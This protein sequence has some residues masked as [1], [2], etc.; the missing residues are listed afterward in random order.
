MKKIKNVISFVE[1]L[2]GKLRKLFVN[3]LTVLFLMLITFGFLFSLGESLFESDKVETEDQILYLEP[4]GV[5]VDKAILT[6]DPFEEFEIFESSINQ[7]ELE[8]FLKIIK[9]AGTDDDLKAIYLDVD[10]L[11]AY[12]TSALKIADALYEAR[13][14]GKEIIAFTSGLGTTGYLMASQATEIIL[15]KDTYEPVLPFGFSRVRLY[16]KDFF[17]NIKVNMNVYAAGDFKSG[18]EGYTRNDMSE[19]DRFAWLEFITPIWEK[20]KSKMEIGRGFESGRIQYIGDNYPLLVSENNGDNNETSLTTGLVDKLM[21]EQ[22]TR[23]YLIEKYGSEEEYERPEGISGREYLS[24]LKD[25]D[26]SNKQKR[27][28]EK[29]KIAIIHVEGAIVTG[30]IGF[31]TAGS[32]G[33]VKKINKARDD[34]NV[35]GIVLRVNSPGGDV[36]A[37]TMI[38][39]ALEEFQSTGRPV[40][41]SMGDIAASGGVWVTTTSEEIWAENT[42]LTGSIGVYGVYPDLSPL[43]KWAGINYDGISMTKAGE[44][45]DVRRGMNEEINKQFREGIENFYKDFVTKVANNREMDFSEVLKV[46]GGRIWRGDK[47]LELGLVDKLGSLDDA[48]NSMVTKL[49]LEDYKAFSY[50]NEVEFEDYLNSLIQGMVPTQ[51]QGL[52]NEI[53]GLNRMFLSEKERY[54]VAYCF[55]CGLRSFE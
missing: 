49:E 19:T 7:I 38:T 33:I 16:Q 13:E 46:A 3:T 27:V 21:S 26:I 50:N 14:N 40:I 23:N 6:N 1:N 4:K 36:Y 11:S 15:E 53:S 25:E 30:N 54:I 17:E 9:N 47:A 44:I 43:A 45:Y 51:I 52:L 31:N 35:I 32:G 24:T 37:S 28:Q 29:N 34:E 22:E 41:T 10:G 18:P 42:T 20:Y 55:D 5:I 2:L 39:N 48:I 12:Y 8:K